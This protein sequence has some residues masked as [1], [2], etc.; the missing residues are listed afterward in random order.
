[1]DVLRVTTIQQAHRLLDLD[2][3]NLWEFRELL[4]FLIWRDIKVRY[5]QTA[6]GIAWFA[7]QP[8]LATLIFT[9]VFGRLARLPSQGVPYAVFA[10][11]AVVPWYFF[12][13]AVARGVNSMVAERHL[14]SKV[15]FPRLLLALGVVVAGLVD[16]AVGFLVLGA[17]LAWYGI[18]PTASILLTP[19][20]LLLAVATAIA[21]VSWLAPINVRYRDVSYTM[22]FLLQIWMFATPVAY[23]IELIPIRWRWLYGL[24][25]MASVVEG[26]RWAWLGTAPPTASLLA[27]SATGVVILLVVGVI[28]FHRMERTFAD[29][30]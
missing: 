23:S 2:L 14:I 27:A 25:P 8:I 6:V 19:L 9:L 18:T 28:F 5:R 15:Y 3:R 12:A 10:Y 29:A 7:L 21:V 13:Q 22:P 4:G 17:M 1:M 11:V 20:F 30:I 26:F 16:F 24:N